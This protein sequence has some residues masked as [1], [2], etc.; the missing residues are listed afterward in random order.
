MLTRTPTPLGK[1][2]LVV[3]LPALILLTSSWLEGQSVESRT[4]SGVIVTQKNEAVEGLSVTALF[5]SGEQTTK[6]DR[7]GNFSLSV[8]NVSLKLKIEGKYVAAQEKVIG[9]ADPV[10][11]LRI[12]IEFVIPPVHESLVITASPLDPSIDRRNN[13]IYK[14]TLFSRD[15]QVFHTLDAGINVG[16]QE[17]GAK[18]LEIR[19]FGFNLDHGGVNGGLK[20]LV[21]G[22]QQNQGTQGHGQGYLAT[23]KALTPELV[24]EVSILNGPFSPEYGDFSGLGVVHIRLK[25][26]LSDRYTARIQGG[27]FNSVRTFLAYSPELKSGDTFFVY[28]G[29]HTDGPFQNPMR[30]DRNNLTGNYT[31]RVEEG[32][33][34]GFKVNFS[35]SNFFSSG[36]IPLDE[37]AAGHLDRFG[38]IDPDLGGN[39]QYGTFGAYRVNPLSSTTQGASRFQPKANVA[40]TPSTRIPLTLYLNYG[41]GISS[42]DA[43]GI[44][45]NPTGVKVST[46]DFYQVGP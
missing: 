22:V 3:L 6:S 27:S 1:T 19:R 26:S 13:A 15:D 4:L 41:R 45:Q 14:N 10:E 34:L 42:Q 23:L 29:S 36:Q 18:S 43:R 33:V 37:V 2:S 44:S 20:I 16:Q 39:L 17:G 28:E 11:N 40:F 24:E 38:F 12:Q 46:T 5:A 8:P 31:K 7:D 25:E 30:Y 21:D 9:P 32:Q 35:A